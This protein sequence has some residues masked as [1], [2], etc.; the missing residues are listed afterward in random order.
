MATKKAAPKK[1]PAKKTGTSMAK[2]DEELARRAQ[3]AAGMEESTLTGGNFIGTRGGVLTYG[4]AEVPGNKMNVIVLGHVLHNVF[5]AGKFDPKNPTSPDCYAFGDREATMVPHEK[6]ED[7]QSGQCEGCPMNEWGTADTG[8]GKACSQKRRLMLLTED[9]LED[10]EDA[11][12]AMLH[13]PVT[14][15][16]AWAGYVVQLATTL[17]RPPLGVI[18]EI[19]LVPDP[20]NQF[21]M[22]F[23]LVEKIDDG[24]VIEALLAKF[25]AHAKELTAPYPAN[26]ER[27]EREERRPAT[28]KAGR[29]VTRVPAKKAAAKKTRR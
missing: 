27:E 3:I 26:S 23:K 29:K 9:A 28:K 25:D 22:K 10:I 8:K 13:V 18:T 16:K 14:S 15:G 24:A 5:Y 2:W 7:Q 19:S 12:A 17:K 6:A 4:G 11:Q 21:A 20:K 1:A